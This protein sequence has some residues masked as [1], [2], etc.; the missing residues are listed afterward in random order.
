MASHH[1]PISGC[2]AQADG[3]NWPQMQLREAADFISEGLRPGERVEMGALSCARDGRKKEDCSKGGGGGGGRGWE[4]KR[5][6]KEKEKLC[7]EKSMRPKGVILFAVT[8]F[9]SYANQTGWL[10]FLF[11]FFFS[12]TPTA[13]P[14][15]SY[16]FLILDYAKVVNSMV[17]SP[18]P[19]GAGEGKGFLHPPTPS[20]GKSVRFRALS[21]AIRFY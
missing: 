4:E 7:V 3:I 9:P 2:R 15:F 21:T 20:L 12:F 11:S 17:M 10:S 5:K 1:P 13:N 18:P 14:R 16:H 19:P 8:C 6:E